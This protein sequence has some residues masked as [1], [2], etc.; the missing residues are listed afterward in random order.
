MTAAEQQ[1]HGDSE[2]EGAG[3]SPIEGYVVDNMEGAVDQAAF[4]A[5][6]DLPVAV[7]G[8]RGTGKM[9][10][11][12]IV[13]T[14]AGGDPENIVVVDCREFRNRV[15]AISSIRRELEGSQG[16]TLV[17]KSP[18]LMH[19]EA[20]RK[21]ARQISTRTFVDARPVRY[22]PNARYVGLFPDTLEHLQADYGLDDALAS[23]FAGYPIYVPPM[24]ERK[25]AVLRWAQKILFQE[26]Q[27][28]QRQVKGF[29]PEA[30]K[31]MLQHEWRG[32]ITEIRQRVVSAVEHTDRAWISEVDLGL[33]LEVDDDPVSRPSISSFLELMD[34][35]TPAEEGYNPTALDE[36]DVA[37]G[38]AVHTVLLSKI[39][40]LGAWLDD[41]LILVVLERYG[42]D[43]RKAADF[44]QTSTRNINRWSSKIEDRT[45]DRKASLLWRE[46]ARLVQEWVREAPVPER[47]AQE[48]LQNLLLIHLENQNA[49]T[50]IKSRS[51]MMAVSIPTYQKRLKIML[52]S[53]QA[54]A[55]RKQVRSHA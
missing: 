4:L 45:R 1:D 37:L 46:P 47:S 13:H 49:D 16:K 20:Q 33:F 6:V 43:A 51:E 2:D 48:F 28:Y 53:S 44:L 19:R 25:K 38:V 36:L 32:N 35:N 27:N 21:L 10:I 23:V 41:E 3:Q 39:E 40:P 54:P 34:K 50:N 14:G 42:G 29:S 9:Y 7:I 26:A 18:H 30:E 52:S 31:A 12:R 11:A 22:L 15:D 5:G 17:F 24:K 8:A 55:D